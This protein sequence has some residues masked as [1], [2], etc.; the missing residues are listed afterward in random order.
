MIRCFLLFLITSGSAVLATD[1]QWM[2]DGTKRTGMIYVPGDA[3]SRPAAGWPTVFVFHGHGGSVDNIRHQFRTDTLWP[4]AVVVY[5]QGLPTVGQI[6]DEQGIRAG[7]DSIDTSDKNRDLRLYDAV[8]KDL[9]DH[10]HI[11]P[12]ACSAQ[13]IQTGVDLLSLCGPTGATR[14]RQ[15]HLPAALRPSKNGRCSNPNLR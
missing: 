5:L 1:Q 12:S 6:T 9:I 15:S 13:A 14:W 11:D 2:V 10:Q 7:W 8:L 4:Q 3:V